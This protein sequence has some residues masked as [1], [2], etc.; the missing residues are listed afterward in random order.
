MLNV[1]AAR[2]GACMLSG[3]HNALSSMKSIERETKILALKKLAT[4]ADRVQAED[5][6]FT[7]NGTLLVADLLAPK[8]A[9]SELVR[10]ALS[11][12]AMMRA[13]IGS[14]V[15]SLGS[16]QAGMD[17]IGNKML[18][19]KGDQAKTAMFISELFDVEEEI[20]H[21]NSFTKIMAMDEKAEISKLYCPAMELPVFP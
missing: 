18:K 17:A 19:G 16:V 10:A 3:A 15:S 7:K 12:T 2:Y 14:L 4:F 5:A 8:D 9:S 6:I 11:R 20:K 21:F 13:F 1:S